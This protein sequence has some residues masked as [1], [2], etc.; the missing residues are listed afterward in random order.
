M[1]VDAMKKFQMIPERTMKCL[2]Y[3]SRPS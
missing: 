3:D 2:K 1:R